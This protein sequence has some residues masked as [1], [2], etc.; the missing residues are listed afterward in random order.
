[1]GRTKRCPSCKIPQAEHKFGKFDKQCPGPVPDDEEE[2]A[3]E[4]DTAPQAQDA[5]LNDSTIQATLNSLLG[6]VQSLTTGLAEVQA[7]NK[8]NVI[9]CHTM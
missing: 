2:L 8:I 9:N 1:M 6:A 3:D 7:D 5:S 4:D